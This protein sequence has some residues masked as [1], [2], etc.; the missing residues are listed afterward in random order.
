MVIIFIFSFWKKLEF[1]GADNFS[2]SN[3]KGEIKSIILNSVLIID[4]FNAQ[5]FSLAYILW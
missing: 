5:Y 3:Q 2:L 1:T 4:V